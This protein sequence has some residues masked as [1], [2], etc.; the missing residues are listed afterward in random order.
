[1]ATFLQQVIRSAVS[2]GMHCW[3]NNC[4][5]RDDVLSSKLATSIRTTQCV[6]LVQTESVVVVRLAESEAGCLCQHKSEAINLSITALTQLEQLHIKTRA[7][8]RNVLFEMK[9]PLP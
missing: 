5:L 2:N 3:C 9:A 4:P 1:M 6:Q 8:Y 7:L